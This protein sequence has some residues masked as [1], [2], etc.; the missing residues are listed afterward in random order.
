MADLIITVFGVGMILWT[1]GGL[2]VA[3]LIQGD[4]DF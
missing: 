3:V 4:E 1:V 2:I